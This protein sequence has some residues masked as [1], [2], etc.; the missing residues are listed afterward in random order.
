[1]R[2]E[3]VLI[4]E[5]NI[6][7][8]SDVL[9]AEE[10]NHKDDVAIGAVVGFGRM[11]AGAVVISQTDTEYLIQWLYVSEVLRHTGVGVGLMEEANRFIKEAGI[12]PVVC[13]FEVEDEENSEILHFFDSYLE[14]N[15]LVETSF[16]HER[17]ITDA[18][19]FYSSP[20][21]KGKRELPGEAPLRFYN[22][23]S[24]YQKKALSMIEDKLS[25]LDKEYFEKT[26]IPELCLTTESGGVPTSIL[27]T[28]LNGEYIVLSFLYGKNPKDLYRILC[29]AAREVEQNFAD[30]KI[31]FDIV[32][33]SAMALSKRFFTNAKQVKIYEAEW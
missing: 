8:F 2:T 18:K 15:I 16:S 23:T 9:P 6:K 14:D 10:F 26:C 5:E 27:L 7:E 30:K 32:S 11:V 25:I 31:L 29:S 1:M 17:Y 22:Q 3:Y 33:E 20:D 28:Q 12:M 21:I 13:Q 19:D 4:T 24:T